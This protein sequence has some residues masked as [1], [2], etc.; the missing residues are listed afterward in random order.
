MFK[1][2]RLGKKHLDSVALCHMKSFPESIS[3][4]LGKRYVKKMLEWYMVSE[5]RFIF[6][7]FEKDVI[8]GYVG[9][10]IGTGSTSA[11]IQ[12]SFWEGVTSLFFKPQVLLNINILKKR[13][14]IFKNIFTRIFYF[15][16]IK[17][18]KS[19]KKKNNGK[20]DSVG[21]IVIGV[22]SQYRRAGIGGL[23]LKRFERQCKNFSINKAHLSVKNNNF[24]AIE[25]Y[26]K[27]G[28]IQESTSEESVKM[29]LKIN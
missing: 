29:I 16:N 20:N 6:G 13:N 24:K 5:N 14:I 27:F 19:G 10:L 21:L 1:V 4:K 2:S 26:K 12:Y 18:K 7:C 23:L 11:M 3:T 22:D 9:G 15:L 17:H 25:A 28:W 8:V